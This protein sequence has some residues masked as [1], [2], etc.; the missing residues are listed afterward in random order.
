[1]EMQLLSS[2]QK[3]DSLNLS[4]SWMETRILLKSAWLH[5]LRCAASQNVFLRLILLCLQHGLCSQSGAAGPRLDSRSQTDKLASDLGDAF[6]SSQI[7]ALQM[8]RVYYDS[9]AK[10]SL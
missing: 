9:L 6:F 10:Y 8:L 5:W 4:E 2:V 3:N 1:M 7:V